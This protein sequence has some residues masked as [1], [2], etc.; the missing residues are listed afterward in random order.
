MTPSL[1]LPGIGGFGI[2]IPYYPFPIAFPALPECLA[3]DLRRLAQS[4]FP[5]CFC[6]SFWGGRLQFLCP[7]YL[8][9]GDPC[10]TC[11]AFITVKSCRYDIGIADGLDVFIYITGKWFPWLQTIVEFVFQTVFFQGP[12]GSFLLNV[13]A[14]VHERIVNF[15]APLTQ[16]DQLAQEWCAFANLLT[17]FLP[18]IGFVI[19]FTALSFVWRMLLMGLGA[20]WAVFVASGILNIIPGLGGDLYASSGGV[21]A[22]QGGGGGVAAVTGGSAPIGRSFIGVQFSQAI[23]PRTGRARREPVFSAHQRARTALRNPVAADMDDLFRGIVNF[24]GALF[25]RGAKQK[26]PLGR[27]RGERK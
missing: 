7:P 27:G 12:F 19:V 17:I 9:S 18:L 1:V 26:K 20:L 23:D 8:I 24:V 4:W 11:P 21:A 14:Y 16:D 3:T 22:S 13:G 10:P 2:D 15:R 25:E 5:V 6:Q